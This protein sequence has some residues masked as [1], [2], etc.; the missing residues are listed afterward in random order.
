LKKLLIL[1]V[2]CIE[3]FGFDQ[4]IASIIFE[5][6]F[7]G[8]FHTNKVYVF[9]KDENYKKV[10]KLSN[11]LVLTN[12]INKSDILIINKKE[13]MIFNNKPIF[14]TKKHILKYKNVIGGFYWVHSEPKIVFI[15]SR[16][17]KYGIVLSHDLKQFLKK[18]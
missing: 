15:K 10:I 7:I 2:F 17:D 4:K 9:T 11:K 3:L 13:N 12:N 8:L 1:F 14:T 6:L 5:K 16:I 18:E